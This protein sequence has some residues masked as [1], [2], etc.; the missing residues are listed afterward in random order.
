MSDKLLRA[1]K[2]LT[3]K[4]DISSGSGKPRVLRV[5]VFQA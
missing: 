4:R 5:N 1:E 2:Q 3:N